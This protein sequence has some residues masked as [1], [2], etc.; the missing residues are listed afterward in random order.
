[1]NTIL[2]LHRQE[3]GQMACTDRTCLVSELFCNGEKD[4]TDGSDEDNCAH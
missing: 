3:E 4:C 1:M 2:T